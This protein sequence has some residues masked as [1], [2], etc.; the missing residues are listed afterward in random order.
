MTP[1]FQYGRDMHCVKCCW[2]VK[3]FMLNWLML[4]RMRHF[5]VTVSS[6]HSA[7]QTGNYCCR[8]TFPQY[9][10]YDC[11]VEHCIIWSPLSSVWKW[12]KNS[13]QTEW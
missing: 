6:M 9:V 12:C 4:T 2:F 7:A 10:C 3:F 8:W 11:H 5:C 13:P 1:T